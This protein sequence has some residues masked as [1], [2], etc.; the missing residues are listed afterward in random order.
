MKPLL[1]PQ[2]LWFGQAPSLEH[3]KEI[4]NRGM[5]LKVVSEH[6]PSMKFARAAVF[7]AADTQFEATLGMLEAHI[8]ACVDQGLLAY[9][10]VSDVAQTTY[11]TQT[12][13]KLVPKHA[14][15][16]N[17]MVRNDE[18]PPYEL[19]NEALLHDPG[20]VA[21]SDL[22]FE[23]DVS[24]LHPN[25]ELLLRR[26][27]HDSTVVAFTPIK[28]GFSGAKTFIVHATVNASPPLPEP[29]PFFVKVGE[30]PKL[31]DEVARFRLH[32]EHYVTWNLRPNFLAERSIYGVSDGVLVG[33]FVEGSRSLAECAR[34]G[35]GEKYI[36]ALFAE[37]LGGWRKRADVHKGR[38]SV[39]AALSQYDR[40]EKIPEERVAQAR[41]LFGGEVLNPMTLWRRLLSSPRDGWK[42][43]VMHGDMHGDNVRV[44][45]DDAI[46]IDFAQSARG[47]A[48][49]DVASLEVWLAFE[50][51]GIHNDRT[52][53]KTWAEELYRPAVIESMVNGVVSGGPTWIH[54]CVA[55]LRKIAKASISAGA[56]E[57][58]RVLAVFLLRH[59]SFESAARNV[60]EEE[61]RRTFAYWLA[62]RLVLSFPSDGKP[63]LAEPS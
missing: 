24:S 59:A 14:A 21:N 30:A 55:S 51:D 23:G 35:G 6:M 61:F 44:R 49:A 46:V 36:E 39:V 13:D 58:K 15:D 9:V 20:P 1:R 19:A 27:F 16:R 11:A 8:T 50:P 18:M 63:A 47:P 3:A 34:S 43:C 31:L 28:A 37:T 32:A 60:E 54:G 4:Q 41:L 33:T 10:V 2:V 17:V 62:N 45:K 42:E 56:D 22:K 5:Q 12:I 40:H 25:H 7:W 57:Y 38:S 52:Q 48:S 29:M 53:W 26:A